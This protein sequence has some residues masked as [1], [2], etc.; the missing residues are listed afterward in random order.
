MK[1]RIRGRDV[2]WFSTLLLAACGSSTPRAQEPVPAAAPDPAAVQ[3]PPPSS[4]RP[5]ADAS[6]APEDPALESSVGKKVRRIIREQLDVQ[7]S[8]IRSSSRFVDDLGGDSMGLVQLVL[9]FDE[10]FEVDIPDEDCEG[11]VTVGDAI[12]YLQKATA[13]VETVP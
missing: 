10:V 11:I 7:D 4:D 1:H 3:T 13:K 2:G 6:K 5:S 12:A 8:E 9:A